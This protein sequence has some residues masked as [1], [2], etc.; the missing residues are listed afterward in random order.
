[1]IVGVAKEAFP[2]ERRVAL[3]P[4][5]VRS[6]VKA[7]FEIM[8]EAGAGVSAGYRDS[9]YAEKGARITPTRA[10]IFRDADIVTQVLSFGSNDVT[11][12]DDLTLYRRDQTVIGFHR[13]FGSLESVQQLAATGVTSFSVEL[14]PRITRAQSM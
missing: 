1:M 3:V 10:E 12:K 11:G 2:G 7:G 4:V 9:E 5:V 14:M 8:I 6:L 13:P